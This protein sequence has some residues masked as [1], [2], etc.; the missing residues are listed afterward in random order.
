VVYFTALLEIRI[1]EI[2]Y[3]SREIF[4]NFRRYYLAR[5]DYINMISKPALSDKRYV[6]DK[7]WKRNSANGEVTVKRKMRKDSE[8][9]GRG[10]IEYFGICLEGLRKG[11]E[12]FVQDCVTARLRNRHLLNTC[13]RSP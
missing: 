13:S 12:T 11:T 7:M 10:L 8:K 3:F 9:S 5:M 2:R 4:F 1:T 6:T